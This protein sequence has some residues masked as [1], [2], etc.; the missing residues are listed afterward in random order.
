MQPAISVQ[1]ILSAYSLQKGCTFHLYGGTL[2]AGLVFGSEGLLPAVAIQVQAGGRRLLGA[3]MGCKTHEDMRGL[4]KLGAFI[5][6]VTPGRT[7]DTVRALF[8]M[9]VAERIFGLSNG[10]AIDCTPVVEFFSANM[11]ERA[12][13]LSTVERIEWPMAQ[14][15]QSQEIAA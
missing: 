4:I 13:K 10:G 15:L 1:R 8:C 12:Q 11:I 5:P 14:R 3:D 7:S 9:H 6:D 2:P